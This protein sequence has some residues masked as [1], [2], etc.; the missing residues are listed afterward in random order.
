M[1]N[2]KLPR[3]L[4]KGDLV[5]LVNIDREGI[6]AEEPKGDGNVSVRIG[7][8]ITKTKEKN[9]MLVG[10]GAISVTTKD[11]KTYYLPNMNISHFANT[12]I[13]S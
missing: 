13:Q 1:E 3:K 7:Q 9:L 8:M 4:K 5:R 2:Y 12:I 6:V 10:D 11:N